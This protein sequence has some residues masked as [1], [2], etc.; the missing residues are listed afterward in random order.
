[1][2][3][4]LLGACLAGCSYSPTPRSLATDGAPGLD[5]ADD[6]PTADAA[7]DA[8]ST[9]LAAATA[10]SPAGHH[11]F[12]TSDGSFSETRTE[13]EASTAHLVKIE[14]MTENLF[15]TSTFNLGGSNFAWIGLADPTSADVYVWTDNTPL[16]GFNAFP[17]GIAPQ[18]NDNCVDSNGSWDPFNCGSTNH[19]GICECE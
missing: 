9:C 18:S 17:G 7:I 13:C 10:T 5:A 8:S 12:L 15:L 14:D 2:R 3:A 6:A 4:L 19:G 1:M 11:Y 16:V